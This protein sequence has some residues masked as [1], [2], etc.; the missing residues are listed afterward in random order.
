[1][2][3]QPRRRLEFASWFL[4]QKFQYIAP[5]VEFEGLKVVKIQVKVCWAVTPCS[6]VT[7][8]NILEDHAASIFRVMAS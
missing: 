1:M 2:V 7:G 5:D 4:L 3:S 6:V 8:T